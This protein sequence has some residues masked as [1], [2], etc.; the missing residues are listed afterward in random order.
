MDKLPRLEIA[1]WILHNA[2]MGLLLVRVLLLRLAAPYFWLLTY[3]AAS[4]AG[5]LA[6][7][8]QSFDTNEYAYTW[9][10][11]EIA[12]WTLA[13]FVTREVIGRVL[14]N[15]QGI[16]VLTRRTLLLIVFLCA[17]G[18]LTLVSFAFD[19]GSEPFPLLKVA[20]LFQQG[21]ALALLLCLVCLVAFVLWF[22]MPLPRNVHLYCFAFA[23][24]LF[25]VAA[26]VGVR[27]FVGAEWTR[28][29]STLSMAL[30]AVAFAVWAVWIRLEN[31]S[32]APTPAIARGPETEERLLAQLASLNQVLESRRKNH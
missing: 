12:K 18:A 2:F 1:I 24:P 29:M 20:L 5:S 9:I 23:L 22:P 17:L 26:T 13:A 11:V 32:G 6:L 16:S 10:A 28:A 19:A 21:V 15:Y 25:A 27:V 7:M 30:Q 4:I 31:E 14:A 8:M 3:L